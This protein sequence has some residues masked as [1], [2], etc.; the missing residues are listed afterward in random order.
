M[1][2][3][4]DPHPLFPTY[5]LARQV[6]AMRLVAEHT[7]AP[8]PAVPWWEPDPGPLGAPFVVMERIDGQVASDVP[9]YTFGGWIADGDADLRL[10]VERSFVSAVARLHRARSD[11]VDLSPLELDEPGSTPL[12]RHVAHQRTYYEWIRG[13]R[14]FPI[15]ERAFDWLSARWP[16]EETPSGIVWG[17]ARL[18]NAMFLGGVVVA[19]LDW[20]GAAVGPPEVDLAWSLYFC[21]YFQRIAERHGH[22]GLPGFM[23]AG[24]VV[25]TYAD[26]TGRPPQDMEWH[27]VYA[28]LRQALTSI[29]VSERAVIRGQQVQ[30]DDPE[31]LIADRQFLDDLLSGR[32]SLDLTTR[33]T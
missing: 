21:D 14:R 6:S 9:P 3:V 23:P 12:Q 16:A 8:V 30:P 24:R 17:D 29:R 25:E 31:D 11:E 15:V 13:K 28:T 18:A 4:G 7:R 22:S 1:P 20:E 10:S 32:A 27:V 19:L 33:S 5:D 2:P 26:L